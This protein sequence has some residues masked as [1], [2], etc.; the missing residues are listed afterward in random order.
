M[1]KN[2]A[3]W[4]TA[5]ICCTFSLAVTAQEVASDG[6]GI[7]TKA[8]FSYSSLSTG[9][10]GITTSVV[11]DIPAGMNNHTPTSVTRYY[12]D[13]KGRLARLVDANIMLRDADVT[14]YVETK[15]EE[16]PS[17]YKSYIYDDKGL[18]TEV[19]TRSYGINDI[20][21][22]GW[23][24]SKT[25]T[26]YEYNADGKCVKMTDATYQVTYTWDGDNMVKESAIYMKKM[27][28]GT[29]V[30]AWA[31]TNVY[32]DFVEGT[33]NLP[34]TVL[35]S[36]SWK[37]YYLIENTYDK[38]N[39]LITVSQYKALNVEKAEDGSITTYEKGD[40]YSQTTNTYDENGL[41][42]SSESGYWYQSGLV[43]DKK[44]VRTQLAN[45]TVAS[46]GY[47]YSTLTKNWALATSLTKTVSGIQN[48][49]TS[50]EGLTVTAK[51]G[52]TNTVIISA[53]KPTVTSA[54]GKFMVYRNGM[55]IGEAVDNGTSLSYEDKGVKNGTYDYFIKQE[56][57]GNISSIVSYT[58]DTQLSAPANLKIVTNGNNAA[59][60]HE[61]VI[62]WAAPQTN[63]PL[64]G[65]YIYA[66][67]SSI[68]TNPVPLNYEDGLLKTTNYK[69]TWS[70]NALETEHKIYVEAVYSI[71]RAASAVVTVS[72]TETGGDEP[73]QSVSVKRVM[74]VMSMGDVMGSVSNTEVSRA[75]IS[76]YDANNRLARRVDYGMQ[77][78]PDPDMPGDT[79]KYGDYIPTDYEKFEYNEKGQLIRV[80]K[81]QYGVF[82]G[83]DRAWKDYEETEYYEYDEQGRVIV[84][85]ENKARRFEYY[86][87]GD[88]LVKDKCYSHSTNNLIYTTIYSNFVTG[89]TNCPQFG[90]RWGEIDDVTNNKCILVFGYD[91][92]GRKILQYT[93]SY[94]DEDPTMKRD[95]EGNVT[96]A[97]PGTPQ[98]EEKW[99]YNE[100][101]EVS[102]YEK[103]R[104]KSNKNAFEPQLKTEYTFEG[105][106]VTATSQSYSVGI[107]AKGGIPT[108]TRTAEY[109]G[110]APTN[111]TASVVENKT[112]AVLLTA[113]APEGAEEKKW[114]VYRNGVRVGQAILVN[115]KL[116][117]EEE[118]VQNGTWDYFMRADDAN[119]YYTSNISN[120][121]EVT[122]ATPLAAV[123]AIT[124]VRNEQDPSTY[125]YQL[126]IAWEAPKTEYTILGYHV[127]LNVLTNNPAP[128]DGILPLKQNE[129]AFTF[130]S[131][132]DTK[133]RI[134]I[135][136]VYNIGKV[137]GAETI[138]NLNKVSNI[139]AAL[140]SRSLF[141]L[142]NQLVV[143][144]AYRSLGIYGIGGAC[145]ATY[146]GDKVIDL[147]TLPAGIYLVKLQTETGV[148]VV[149]IVK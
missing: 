122:F 133:K 126:D 16:I 115:G 73:D 100:E 31:Y 130:A 22:Y 120:P 101:G 63:L 67:V 39:Q 86:Y 64:L 105:T 83:Y 78:G 3:N 36:D 30:G 26:S 128:F 94:K 15:G 125:D 46:W 47:M 144:I 61:V 44:T 118:L 103:S 50:P 96:F 56:G 41:Q 57:E 7:V 17:L 70:A 82:S 107:W 97:T 108:V 21:A 81:R 25:E 65:Y 88:R 8:V 72:K 139:D 116:S 24:D 2:Y 148:E 117:F 92:E 62:S 58:F 119:D 75:L 49:A 1:K 142:G 104:W 54:D 99:S 68:N 143:N 40:L 138:I 134:I 135:E 80:F 71:G 33:P 19:K 5:L 141:V 129:Y 6:G 146:S 76:Y 91:K 132:T 9:D 85:L 18:L 28:V 37:Q 48:P 102:L 87:E 34:K 79:T 59:G 121:V 140:I 45:D 114:Y 35:K 20:Y 98:F 110:Y 111:L 69:L 12:Y 137:K 112:N 14:E 149:K 29:S 123:D 43:P 53:M 13:N 95:D 147:G 131:D 11:E 10:D 42:I 4:L 109:L 106:D 66:D 32:A 90:F 113:D 60:D 93:Y 55:K 38:K 136:T 127:F 77:L 145:V 51:S 89:Q 124:V 27:G 23:A 84:Q 74:A 52:E